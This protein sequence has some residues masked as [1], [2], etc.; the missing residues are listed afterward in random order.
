MTRELEAWNGRK[1]VVSGLATWALVASLTAW[2]AFGLG[3]LADS[4][5][6]VPYWLLTS[7]FVLA[8]PSLLTLIA[9][10]VLGR[11]E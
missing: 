9:V 7:L 3:Q 10:P 1:I 4:V 5:T 11:R 2:V 8:L 6:D